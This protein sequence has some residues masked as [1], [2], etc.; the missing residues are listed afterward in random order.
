MCRP[1]V[2]GRHDVVV[3]SWG[4]RSGL[5]RLTLLRVT[6]Y[7]PALCSDLWTVLTHK[8]CM[9]A[10]Q[11]TLDH[12]SASLISRVDA[13]F[14]LLTPAV[15][16]CHQSRCRL[17]VAGLSRLLLPNSGTVCLTA[18]FLSTR[19]RPSGIISNIICSR[20]PTRTLFC[21]FCTVTPLV[22][23]AVVSYLGHSKKI[24]ID[25]LIDWDVRWKFRLSVRQSVCQKRA[26]WR[27]FVKFSLAWGSAYLCRYRL[28]DLL[29]ISP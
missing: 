17:S 26:L 12:L 4:G 1:S 2:L 27:L 13:L 16:W 9:E 25:W 29:P 23:L 15:L 3:A 5:F 6:P 21:D 22:V 28:G 18:S 8:I 10:R 7:T 20:S 14:V 24:L 11:L 19:L